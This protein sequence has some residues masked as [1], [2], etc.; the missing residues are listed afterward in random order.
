GSGGGAALPKSM[1]VGGVAV[2]GGAADP[3]GRLTPGRGTGTTPMAPG[4]T[5]TV[6]GPATD[7]G[8][9]SFGLPKAT[10]IGTALP[11][12]SSLGFGPAQAAGTTASTA[13]AVDRARF[14]APPGNGSRRTAT[15]SAH[16]TAAGAAAP[17][18]SR[19]LA[20]TTG[21]GEGP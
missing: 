17:R 14:I 8:S 5:S 10:L 15:A 7:P 1:V 19:H 9:P 3:A 11:P 20:G 16:R 2:V 13:S 6:D 18:T 4:T 21:T 12:K